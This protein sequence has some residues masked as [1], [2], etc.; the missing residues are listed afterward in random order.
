MKIAKR[1]LTFA[2]VAGL[3]CFVNPKTNFFGAGMAPSS[4]KASTTSPTTGTYKFDFTITLASTIASTTKIACIAQIQVT[5]D[6]QLSG[7]QQTAASAAIVS[8]K[9]AT[10][11]VEIPYSWDLANPTTDKLVRL[12]SIEAPVESTVGTPLPYH[13]GH[14]N[15]GSIP[16]PANGAITTEVLTAT[17]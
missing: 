16:M 7:I 4:V 2:C 10:C 17:L 13:A 5:G 9:T 6:T 14:L 12:Y 8:G 15:L 11:S 1:V 3:L